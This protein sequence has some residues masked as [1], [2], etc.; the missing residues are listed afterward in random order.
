MTK[1]SMKLLG[2]KQFMCWIDVE[3]FEEIRKAA[4]KRTFIVQEG[5][6]YLLNRTQTNTQINVLE[7]EQE[8]TSMKLMKVNDHLQKM[9]LK[10]QDELDTL[11]RVSPAP[12][13]QK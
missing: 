8:E 10:V 6:K 9:L 11:K 13:S 3:L 1:E 2:K 12:P 5:F 7:L 4:F